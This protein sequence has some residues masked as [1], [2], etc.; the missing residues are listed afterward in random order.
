M[1]PPPSIITVVLAFAKSVPVIDSKQS[2]EYGLFFICVNYLSLAQLV[3][4]S[5]ALQIK[6]VFLTRASGGNAVHGRNHLT[7]VI[8]F[9]SHYDL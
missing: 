9:R 7:R 8:N 5:V 3:S 4:P 1:I 2:G 6:L